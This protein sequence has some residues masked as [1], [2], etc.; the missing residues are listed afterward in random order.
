MSRI[1]ARPYLG[2]PEEQDT[3]GWTWMSLA[4]DMEGQTE[5]VFREFFPRYLVLPTYQGRA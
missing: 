2:T 4:C 5:R 1:N 3:L